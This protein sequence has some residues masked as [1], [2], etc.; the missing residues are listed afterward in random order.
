MYRCFQCD[1]PAQSNCA[2]Y[3]QMEH[4]DDYPSLTLVGRLREAEDKRT[5][6]QVPK[7][8]NIASGEDAGIP[9]IE[10]LYAEEHA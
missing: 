4:P 8:I 7:K 6:A 10:H 1:A 3:T 2:C 9:G 5:P